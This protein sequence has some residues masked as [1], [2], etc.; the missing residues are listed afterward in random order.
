[1]YERKILRKTHT[2][3]RQLEQVLF[4]NFVVNRKVHAGRS[5]TVAS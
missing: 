1:M 4:G 5:A 2:L 3:V